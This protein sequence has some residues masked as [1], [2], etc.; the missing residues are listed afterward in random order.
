LYE[1]KLLKPSSEFTDLDDDTIIIRFA[2]D[3]GG[4]FIQFNFGVT[5]MNY[6]Q[7]NSPDTFELCLSLDAPESYFNLETLFDLKV[8]EFEFYFWPENP[9]FY[10]P[11]GLQRQQHTEK[12]YVERTMDDTATHSPGGPYTTLNNTSG[13]DILVDHGVAWEMEVPNAD[14][15]TLTTARRF[16]NDV[17]TQLFEEDLKVV[18]YKLHCVLGG[19]I[20]FLK[21][22]LGLMNCSFT[23]PFYL[24]EIKLETLKRREN[25]MAPGETRTPARFEEQLNNVQVH[26]LIGNRRKSRK[27]TSRHSAS[28]CFQL[29]LRE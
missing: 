15:D 23:F 8:E 13:I 21:L 2:G 7:A 11:N 24:R 25:G 19:E 1:A 27:W 22:V 26:A 3:K 14:T 29:R 16:R 5:V 17:A 28:G 9:T 10:L 6:V 20:E 12:K 18:D 4:R